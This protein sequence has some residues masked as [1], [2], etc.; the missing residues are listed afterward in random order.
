MS[1]PQLLNRFVKKLD[2][3]FKTYRKHIPGLVSLDDDF[4]LARPEII[5]HLDR[6]QAARLGLTTAN[7]AGTMRTAINGTEASTYRHGD[8]DI[9]IT[10]R[11]QEGSRT[12][13]EDLRK[14][15][16][17]AEGGAQIPVCRFRRSLQWSDPRP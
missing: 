12:S 4:D 13:L 8:D 3:H 1:K 6:T 17:V 16:I 7:V 10:V 5:V 15:A 9:D 2:I 14:L 11:L